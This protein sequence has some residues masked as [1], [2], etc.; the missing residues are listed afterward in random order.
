MRSITTA[1]A[2]LRQPGDR[3]YVY[4]G[5]VP[6]F[7]YYGDTTRMVR[8]GCH[9]ND[10]RKYLDELDAFRGTPRLWLVVAHA[11]DGHGVREDSL[12][13]RYLNAT[14]QAYFTLEARSAF[15]VLYDLR[16]PKPVVGFAAP[17]STR[18][19]QPNLVCR[20]N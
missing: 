19:M 1:M 20:V 5:A 14:G 10:W 8:G 3:V 9:R 17:Q 7:T 11:F 16:D 2:P 13:V 18:P 4:Y 15:A 6:T 12:L